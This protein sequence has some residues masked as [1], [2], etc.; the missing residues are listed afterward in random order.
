MKFKKTITAKEGDRELV[1]TINYCE[2]ANWESSNVKRNF[3]YLMDA[4]FKAV[5]DNFHVLE[6]KI[7]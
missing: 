1:V 3:Q 5:E 2:K 6:I 7:K 4:L